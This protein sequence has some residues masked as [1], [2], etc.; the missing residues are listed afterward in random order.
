[1]SDGKQSWMQ[2]IFLD[3]PL[4]PPTLSQIA[5]KITPR[6]WSYAC[7]SSWEMSDWGRRRSSAFLEYLRQFMKGCFVFDIYV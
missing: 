3:H 5:V 2:A 1:M 6:L 4:I 7:K